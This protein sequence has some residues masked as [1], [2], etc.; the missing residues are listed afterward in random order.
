MT[1]SRFSHTESTKYT[2][3]LIYQHDDGTLTIGKPTIAREFTMRASV[4][5]VDCF[6]LTAS[7]LRFCVRQQKSKSLF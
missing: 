5:S 2:D 4:D 3:F 1:S 7:E 6:S